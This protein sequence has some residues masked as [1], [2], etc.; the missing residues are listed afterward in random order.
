[1]TA[2]SRWRQRNLYSSIGLLDE[3]LQILSLLSL[4]TLPIKALYLALVLKDCTCAALMRRD[5]EGRGDGK[6]LINLEVESSTGSSTLRDWLTNPFW[7]SY[8]C[9]FTREDWCL[10]SLSSE[11]GKRS[12]SS[13]I[14]LKPRGVVSSARCLGQRT[15]NLC[16]WI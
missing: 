13:K 8:Q 12:P 14:I 10:W 16:H 5:W 15:E 4:L 2:F 9:Q 3:G 1:M 7:S 11:L 6:T